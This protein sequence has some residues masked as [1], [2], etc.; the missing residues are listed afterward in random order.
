MRTIVVLIDISIKGR[1]KA[2]SKKSKITQDTQLKI[3]PSIT[4]TACTIDK[5]LF[6]RNKT[7]SSIEIISPFVH[8]RENKQQN[9]ILQMAE[10]VS[11][12]AWDQLS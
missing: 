11:K 12:G 10:R 1:S 6:F 3:A 4:C 7:I 9:G 8:Y 5:V 2:R